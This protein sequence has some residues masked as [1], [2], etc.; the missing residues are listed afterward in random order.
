M[1]STSFSLFTRILTTAICVVGLGC[2]ADAA[3][4]SNYPQRERGASPRSDQSVQLTDAGIAALERGDQVAAREL[5]QR[6]LKANPRN[7]AAHTYLGIIADRAGALVEAEQ[8]FA[9]AA[10]HA[11]ASPAAHNNHGAVLLRLGR[12][13]QAA[14]QFEAS[15]RLDPKQPSALVNLAQIRF[16]S[17]TPEALRAARELFER[18][19]AIAPEAEVSRA[20]V[21]IALRLGERQKAVE[22]F[23][24]YAAALGEAKSE[25]VKPAARAELGAALFEAGLF[26][27]ALA[28][29]SAAVALDPANADAVLWLALTQRE[30]KDIAAA[31]RTLEA[32]IARGIETPALYAALAE[33][34]EASGHIENAIPAMRLAIERDPQNE[35]YRFRYG[36]LLTDT[37]APAA[38][39]IRLQESLT[40]F[41]RS[42]KLWFALGVAQAA[43]D[44]YDEAA[45]SFDRA[46]EF[47]PRFAPALA[48]LGMTH[49][50]QGRF[51][52][53][54]ALYERALAINDQLAAAHYL[55]ADA[56]LQQQGAD[57]AR[58]ERHLTRSVELDPAFLPARLALAKLYLRTERAT[59]AVAQLERIVAADPAQADAQYQLG[60]AYRRLKRMTEAQTALAA[61]KR[62]SETQRTQSQ[63]GQKEIAR[64]LA[65]VRF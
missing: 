15:L 44:K 20:L 30:R 34:Y 58:L 24:V 41:P 13:A 7:E 38:A 62:L 10:R 31:G 3:H 36:M 48:Y 16:A 40:L 52:E 61:F 54:V 46:L 23:R 11:P 19:H 47:E 56:M 12:T 6:A 35:A 65:N 17:G 28:E 57:N 59:E 4:A 50:Q 43:S 26:E 33:V 45:R 49:A 60:Q 29:L 22:N 9:A 37:K 42:S 64:R 25:V 63:E 32:A 55:L 18:A 5:F 2:H 39:I 14:A 51:G 53:A 8:H 21:V 27:E 1:M